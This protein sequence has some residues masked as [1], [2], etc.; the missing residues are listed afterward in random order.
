MP[1]IVSKDKN[2]SK[3][4]GLIFT[5]PKKFDAASKVAAMGDEKSTTPSQINRHDPHLQK[6]LELIYQNIKKRF[7]MI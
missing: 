5:V 2:I 6:V 1:L 3:Q 4:M 7:N